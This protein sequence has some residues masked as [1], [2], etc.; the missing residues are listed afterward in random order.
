[1]SNRTLGLMVSAGGLALVAGVIMLEASLDPG[2]NALPVAFSVLAIIMGVGVGLGLYRFAPQ[3]ET[4]M[5]RISMRAVSI[6]AAVLGLGFGLDLLGEEGFL[7]FLV[8]YSV[9]LFILPVAL[10]VLGLALFSSRALPA[11][12]KAVP[13]AMA[14]VAVVTYFFHAL[15]RDV[16]DPP[17]AVWLVSLGIGWVLLGVGISRAPDMDSAVGQ[18]PIG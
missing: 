4:R 16:W 15:L 11:W 7:G 5:A 9:G 12:V 2:E 1:M 8:A 14:A 3:L 10:L 6:C 13:L 18:T 17:D